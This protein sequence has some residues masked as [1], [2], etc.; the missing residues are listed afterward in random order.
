L[1]GLGGFPGLAASL[2]GQAGLLMWCL[3]LGCLL[4]L[5][6][7][8]QNLLIPIAVFLALFDIWLVFAPDGPVGQIA[9]GNQEQLAQIAYSVPR[10]ASAPTG[11]RPQPLAYIGPADFMFSAMF[12]AALY[13]FGLDVRRTAQ[14]LAPVLVAYLL[15]ALLAGDVSIGPIRLAALPALLPIAAV[16]LAV[17]GRHF[18]LTRDEWTS[19]AVLGGLMLAFVVWRFSVTAE[20]VPPP[21][22]SSSNS[23]PEPSAT[24][25]TPE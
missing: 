21:T 6:L 1:R 5:A 17:N 13:R 7:K 15:L 22:P 20:P 16:V 3:G 9:R 24:A 18:R 12:F 4:A 14:W 25:P 8:D 2:A 10:P 23:A 19:T 11:G